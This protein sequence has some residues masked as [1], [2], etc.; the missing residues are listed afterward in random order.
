MIPAVTPDLLVR[1]HEIVRLHHE[2]VVEAIVGAEAVA[3]IVVSQLEQLGIPRWPDLPVHE[4]ARVFGYLAAAMPDPLAMAEVGLEELERR[5]AAHREIPLSREEAFAVRQAQQHAAVYCRGLGNRV[6]IVTGQVAIEADQAQRVQYEETIRDET[7]Q[8]VW[9]RETADQLRSRLG[10]AT[11]NWTRDLKR[12]AATEINNAMQQG[13]GDRIAG[14]YGEDA[15]VA[16][17][18]NPG[19]CPKCLQAYIGPDGKPRIFRLSAI[20]YETNARDPADPTRARPQ[21]EW[22]P[23]LE[24]QHPWC[25]CQST[26]VPDGWTFTED[27]DLEPPE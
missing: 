22:V 16:K 26:R 12:I 14:E 17:I 9:G 8:A 13:R 11:G 18:P 24:S 25:R 19:A 5:L 27:W 15:L 20:R 6:D 23:T 3:P 21:A 10:R 7:A 1:L 4:Q 2:A